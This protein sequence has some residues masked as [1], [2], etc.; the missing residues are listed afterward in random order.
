MVTIEEEI[1]QFKK[2]CSSLIY[3]RKRR[4]EAQYKLEEIKVRLQG[5]SSPRLEGVYIV[6]DP[7]KSDKA[8]WLEEESKW[9]KERDKWQSRIDEV[10][11][12]LNL[13]KNGKDRQMIYDLC[14]YK[15]NHEKT[16]K[17]YHFGT[18]KSMYYHVDRVL[19]RIL[20]QC[21]QKKVI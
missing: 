18:R 13:I 21:E 10:K 11:S 6:K 7:H 17:K 3:W 5:V 1:T 4:D 9:M 15:R 19:E 8:Y 12:K 16:A 20:T 14:V 2:D